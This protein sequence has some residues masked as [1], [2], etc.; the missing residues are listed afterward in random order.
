M[1]E[2]ATQTMLIVT[3]APKAKASGRACI[4]GLV[5]CLGALIMADGIETIGFIGLGVMGETMCR[6]LVQRGKWGIIAYDL[7]PEPIAVWR[8]TA[9]NQ[10][11]P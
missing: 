6:N 1:L 8:R 10:H 2:K 4:R 5:D 7:N 9:L 11:C 3:V